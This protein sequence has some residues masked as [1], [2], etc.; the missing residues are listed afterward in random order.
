VL[1]PARFT[2]PASQARV[3]V[4]DLDHAESGPNFT[5]V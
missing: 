1:T 3:G 5:A 4:C 2:A